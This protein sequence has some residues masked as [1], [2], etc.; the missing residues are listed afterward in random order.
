[1]INEY[2]S[3]EKIY[4]ADTDSYGVV[5]HG[6]YIKWFEKGRCEFCEQNGLNL[7]ELERNNILFPVVELNVKYLSSVLSNDTIEVKTTIE[8]LNRSSIVF[9][10][11]IESQ[12]Q[13]RI[14]TKATSKIVAIEK[15]SKKLIRKLPEFIVNKLS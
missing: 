7:D 9:N 14:C 3:K 12:T 15:D 6:A 13:K 5:W 10:H 1:M 2:I 4:Y 8:E 11:T